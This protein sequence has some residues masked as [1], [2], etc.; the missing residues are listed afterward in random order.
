MLSEYL[1]GYCP[2]NS[3]ETEPMSE[4]SPKDS[5][6]DELAG[7]RIKLAFAKKGIDR[8]DIDVACLFKDDSFALIVEEDLKAGT[9]LAKLK[10][11]QDVP[12]DLSVSISEPVYHLRSILDQLV[13]ALAEKFGVLNTKN[14][15]F[16]FGET[17]QDIER[18][19]EKGGKI[20]GLPAEVQEIIVALEPHKNGQ[21]ELW[22][23]GRLGNI[24]KHNRL[25]PIGYIGAGSLYQNLHVQNANIGIMIGGPGDLEKGI[26]LSDLGKHGTICNK[27]GSWPTVGLVGGG[28][29]I[30]IS[31]QLTFGDVD[32]FEGKPVVAVLRYLYDTTENI[33]DIFDQHFFKD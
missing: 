26:V 12:K 17:D 25:I 1:K 24:D 30:E 20:Y 2:F 15:L 27:Q 14:L 3:E 18:A 23:L 5:K 6:V 21:S 7:I 31:A 16:P 13:V 33:V 22:A 29:N 19:K 11:K 32:V 10:L 4:N 8:I 9:R 28:A